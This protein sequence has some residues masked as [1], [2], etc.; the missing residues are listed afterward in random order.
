M[1]QKQK[2]K[3]LLYL[4]SNCHVYLGHIKRKRAKREVFAFLL[5]K[6]MSET[7]VFLLFHQ[8]SL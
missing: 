8:S 4:G 3:L 7:T 5:T 6:N 2:M 1:S